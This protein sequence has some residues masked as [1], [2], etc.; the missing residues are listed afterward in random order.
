MSNGSGVLAGFLA[1]VVVAGGVAAAGKFVADGIV[2]NRTADRFVTVKGLAER[3]V[4]AD[5]AVWPI[6]IVASGNDLQSVQADIEADIAALNGFVS[7]AGFD[8]EEV[9]L[10]RIQVEDRVAAGYFDPNRQQ[11]RYTIRQPVVVR[12]D[13]VELVAE[14]SRELGEVVR[15]GVV[16]QDW[17]GPSFLFTRLNDVKPEMIA[18]ATAAARE[19]AQQFADDADTG[20]GALRTANQGVFVIRPRDDFPGAMESQQ[21]FKTVRV[22]TTVSYTLD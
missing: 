21:V 2:E 11:T 1:A 6:T 17:Q 13:K 14:T 5:L 7:D 20:L 16:M 18:E 9:S 15:Q 19:A 4:Q 8:G 10:G 12:T 22:V 3:D